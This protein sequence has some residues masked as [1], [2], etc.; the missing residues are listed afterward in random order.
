MST[1]PVPRPQEY[2]EILSNLRTY[3]EDELANRPLLTRDQYVDE[4]YVR[5][6]LD[7]WN[8]QGDARYMAQLDESRTTQLDSYISLHKRSLVLRILPYITRPLEDAMGRIPS[9]SIAIYVTFTGNTGGVT[10]PVGLTGPACDIVK[11]QY[12]RT[13]GNSALG[14]ENQD[15]FNPSALMNSLAS[16]QTALEI[17]IKIA[18]SGM[19]V[20]SFPA[21]KPVYPDQ[22]PMERDDLFFN[23]KSIITGTLLR[24]DQNVPLDR[25]QC[26]SGPSIVP[27]KFKRQSTIARDPMSSEFSS[28][29]TRSV[30]NRTTTFD[31]FFNLSSVPLVIGTKEVVPPLCTLRSWKS[32]N[33]SLNENSIE[34]FLASKLTATNPVIKNAIQTV[35]RILKLM[36][37]ILGESGVNGVD[38]FLEHTT[39]AYLI[40]LGRDVINI[41]LAIC[42]LGNLAYVNASTLKKG[43][44]ASDQEQ[45]VRFISASNLSSLQSVYENSEVPD[46]MSFDFLS[47]FG[48]DAWKIMSAMMLE[49]SKGAPKD[50]TP[51]ANIK[52][53]TKELLDTLEQSTDLSACALLSLTGV[54]DSEQVIE[55]S[56]PR[57]IRAMLDTKNII[58]QAE[59]SLRQLRVFAAKEGETRARID[60]FPG[61][62]DRPLLS[63]TIIYDPV[64]LR[65]REVLMKSAKL[66]VDFR[67]LTKHIGVPFRD[68]TTSAPST[69]LPLSD[70]LVAAY[71]LAV[72]YYSDLS[73]LGP[74]A[75]LECFQA[76]GLSSQ[77]DAK[78]LCD[79]LRNIEDIIRNI[80]DRND[81]KRYPKHV[82]E[83]YSLLKPL[84]DEADR[85]VPTIFEPLFPGIHRFSIPIDG[86]V[87]FRRKAGDTTYCDAKVLSTEENCKFFYV[88][89]ESPSEEPRLDLRSEPRMVA[90]ED[91]DPGPKR[92]RQTESLQRPRSPY[93]QDPEPKRLR[94]DE[95]Q[96]ALS[97]AW[98]GSDGKVQGV[99]ILQ[100][101]PSIILNARRLLQNDM[102]SAP[103]SLRSSWGNLESSVDLHVKKIFI[104]QG[105]YDDVWL[106]KLPPEH[107]RDFKEMMRQGDGVRCN[108]VVPYKTGV[109]DFTLNALVVTKGGCSITFDYGNHA[110]FPYWD[111]RALGARMSS[112]TVT[113]TLEGKSIILFGGSQVFKL[114]PMT[115][116][117]EV[118]FFV[119]VISTDKR[120]ESAFRPIDKEEHINVETAPTWFTRGSTRNASLSLLYAATLQYVSLLRKD[121]PSPMPL[122]SPPPEEQFVLPFA[123]S[124]DSPVAIPV[125]EPCPFCRKPATQQY[126]Y[127]VY[128]KE[129]AKKLDSA[130]PSDWEKG[131]K[132]C[133]SCK[134]SLDDMLFALEDDF[135]AEVAFVQRPVEYL[136][137]PIR[138]EPQAL[139][140]LVAA[141]R[142]Q[143]M[144]PSRPRPATTTGAQV[145]ADPSLL[146]LQHM[147][148]GWGFSLIYTESTSGFEAFAKKY[149][150]LLC[151]ENNSARIQRAYI[152]HYLKQSDIMYRI[153]WAAQPVAFLLLMSNK[154]EKKLYLPLVCK[155]PVFLNKEEGVQEAPLRFGS[156]LLYAAIK[157]A[158]LIGFPISLHASRAK[159]VGWYK[160]HGFL[161]DDPLTPLQ[162]NTPQKV[163]EAYEYFLRT[164]G[165]QDEDG[166]KEF[167]RYTYENAE[168]IGYSMSIPEDLL[169]RAVTTCTNYITTEIEQKS[170]QKLAGY[171]QSDF[172]LEERKPSSRQDL[173]RKSDQAARL[174]ATKTP[175]HEKLDFETAI[176][177]L[178]SAF[179]T[180]VHLNRRKVAGNPDVPDAEMADLTM[181]PAGTVMAKM[182]G[183][184][185]LRNNVALAVKKGRY[186]SD[187]T[188]HVWF[189]IFQYMDEA[190]LLNTF[191]AFSERPD[192]LEMTM[193]YSQYIR[194]QISM[195][196]DN[197]R[198]LE[199]FLTPDVSP[200]CLLTQYP[201]G[202]PVKEWA[203]FKAELQQSLLGS[204]KN[205]LV[206]GLNQLR[207]LEVIPNVI[208]VTVISSR[209]ET[210][211]ERFITET[212]KEM[213]R[214]K[215]LWKGWLPDMEHLTIND[216]TRFIPQTR[217]ILKKDSDPPDAYEGLGQH[218]EENG[219]VGRLFPS[220][221]IL[222]VEG[223][224]HLRYRDLAMLGLL[225]VEGIQRGD[226]IFERDGYQSRT[227]LNANEWPWWTRGPRMRINHLEELKASF[228]PHVSFRSVIESDSLL[229]LTCNGRCLGSDALSESNAEEDTFAMPP[230]VCDFPNLTSLT[231][232]VV[233]KR[234]TDR[235]I[236]KYL[237]R[238]FP[239][240]LTLAT[241]GESV[242][243]SL[244]HHRYPNLESLRV[245]NFHGE[246]KFNA[247]FSDETMSFTAPKLKTLIMPG[248]HLLEEQ[249]YPVVQ[250]L[251]NMDSPLFPNLETLELSILAFGNGTLL[252]NF[253]LLMRVRT[254][255][256]NYVRPA[257]APNALNILPRDTN[258]D[259]VFST[260]R[261]AIQEMVCN[262]GVRLIVRDLHLTGMSDRRTTYTFAGLRL[263]KQGHSAPNN[264]YSAAYI[265]IGQGTD[266][267]YSEEWENAWPLCQAN[268]QLPSVEAYIDKSW[269]ATV[270]PSF[271][272]DGN[273]ARLELENFRGDI[274]DVYR[275]FP[276]THILRIGP[277][278]K[279]QGYTDLEELLSIAFSNERTVLDKDQPPG[280]RL[281]L[282]PRMDCIGGAMYPC[283]YVVACRI[284]EH[285]PGSSGD[286]D[287]RRLNCFIA[288]LPL[289]WSMP[290]PPFLKNPSTRLPEDPFLENLATC[291]VQGVL[292][293]QPDENLPVPV[294][295]LRLGHFF[296][297]SFRLSE[298]TSQRLPD[299]FYRQN[300]RQP[301][302]NQR[303]LVREIQQFLKGGYITMSSRDMTSCEVNFDQRNRDLAQTIL[304]TRAEVV[305]CSEGFGLDIV[306]QLEEVSELTVYPKGTHPDPSF[307]KHWPNSRHSLSKIA[308]G[309]RTLRFKPYF[310]LRTSGQV[311]S[312]IN[313]NAEQTINFRLRHRFYDPESHTPKPKDRVP[314][315]LPK[316][317]HLDYQCEYLDEELALDIA[318]V[319]RGTRT[320]L[321]PQGLV[322]LVITCSDKNGGMDG[323][324]QFPDAWRGNSVKTLRVIGSVP[325]GFDGWIFPVL[326][327]LEIDHRKLNGLNP[328]EARSGPGGYSRSPTGNL[329]AWNFPDLSRLAIFHVFNN[330][331]H[332]FSARIVNEDKS[333]VFTAPLL[334]TLELRNID[335]DF[336]EPTWQAPSLKKIT[337]TSR[338]PN[339][340]RDVQRKF[341]SVNLRTPE[342]NP[343]IHGIFTTLAADGFKKVA[344]SG[345][346]EGSSPGSE[347][348]FYM[349]NSSFNTDTYMCM[350]QQSGSD[351]HLLLLFRTSLEGN[352]AESILSVSDA[353]KIAKATGIKGMQALGELIST[354]I[355]NG[356]IVSFSDHELPM[357]NVEGSDSIGEMDLAEF[358]YDKIT[359]S[360][361]TSVVLLGAKLNSFT[362]G[363]IPMILFI[364]VL[365]AIPTLTII[366]AA[367]ESI[368]ELLQKGAEGNL[369]DLASL[370]IVSSL[371][372]PE[373]SCYSRL[374]P[375]N[376]SSEDTTSPVKFK[377]LPGDYTVNRNWPVWTNIDDS[378]RIEYGRL[379]VQ[380]LD[381]VGFNFDSKCL[382][383]L[384]LADLIDTDLRGQR[385]KRTY[386]VRPTLKHLR[387]DLDEQALSNG[388]PDE[389]RSSYLVELVVRA[390]SASMDPVDSSVFWEFPNLQILELYNVIMATGVI[391]APKLK[392]FVFNSEKPALRL[393]T[394]NNPFH[395]IVS[396]TRGLWQLKP[397]NHSALEH[398]ETNYTAS[399]SSVSLTSVP[400]LEA[401]G[402]NVNQNFPVLK[403]LAVSNLWLI[404]SDR[405]FMVAHYNP[406]AL[407]PSL[408]HLHCSEATFAIPP[409]RTVLIG[410]DADDTRETFFT[411][412]GLDYTSGDPD[413][414][415]VV[416][417][418]STVTYLVVNKLHI[419]DADD[420][421]NP[422]SSRAVS[423]GRS[424]S[425]K[426]FHFGSPL[427]S[428][429][430][431]KVT[432]LEIDHW[433]P[434]AWLK[435]PPDTRPDITELYI[436][437][438]R[439]ERVSELR[440]LVVLPHWTLDNPSFE[441]LSATLYPILRTYYPCLES[442]KLSEKSEEVVCPKYDL[443]E[444]L[445]ATE[446]CRQKTSGNTH[447]WELKGCLDVIRYENVRVAVEELKDNFARYSFSHLDSVWEFCSMDI[448]MDATMDAFV[449]KYEEPE[450]PQ[451][452]EE[453]LMPYDSRH[454]EE[455]RK[456][457]SL[458]SRA[459]RGSLNEAIVP[460]VSLALPHG[461][462][463]IKL[464]RNIKTLEIRC[465]TSDE[466][467]AAFSHKE[468]NHALATVETLVF[469]LEP[470]AKTYEHG[471][472]SG[473]PR[474]VYRDWSLPKLRTL[475]F[476]RIPVQL[477]HLD[478]L[479]LIT[480]SWYLEKAI[481][482]INQITAFHAFV[483]D[484]ADIHGHDM[485]N[486]GVY[487]ASIEQF[488]VTGPGQIQNVDFPNA[489]TETR[490]KPRLELS[491]GPRLIQQ[492]PEDSGALRISCAST[493]EILGELAKLTQ[494]QLRH[495][496]HLH[497]NRKE[498][499]TG[500]EDWYIPESWPDYAMPSLIGVFFHKIPVFT[501]HLDCLGLRDQHGTG[502][503]KDDPEGPVWVKQL[504]HLKAHFVISPTELDPLQ[505]LKQRGIA[506]ATIE[507]LEYTGVELNIDATRLPNLI[508][509]CSNG[510]WGKGPEALRLKFPA[511]QIEGA[512]DEDLRRSATTR[513]KFPPGTVR[514]TR[515]G[516][517]TFFNVTSRNGTLLT[518][519]V[520][521]LPRDQTQ[522]VATIINKK[523][524]LY[525]VSKSLDLSDLAIYAPRYILR[526]PSNPLNVTI[527]EEDYF[528]D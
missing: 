237:D 511:I 143:P 377:V 138:A 288:R 65:L 49:D 58:S 83:L 499:A 88:Q 407:F 238:V 466:L 18:S 363:F 360:K 213:V 506:S 222:H 296:Q 459:K 165:K 21:K 164:T 5:S 447:Q 347:R 17:D 259:C 320:L 73:S 297:A 481:P 122:V 456:W 351:H 430:L 364:P 98:H 29:T 423:K 437:S 395:I 334:K 31:L 324:G 299:W 433:E 265:E 512:S 171:T 187:V 210:Y 89:Y 221:K 253:P 146:I 438:N 478:C 398:Y 251:P 93:D 27:A 350:Y 382:Y 38:V 366:N 408:T 342:S 218:F 119:Y 224:G 400:D 154:I 461:L 116:D 470:T 276:S 267:A 513:T 380:Q 379:P 523:L 429:N 42:G 295:K 52:G 275:A 349:F 94:D 443:D 358:L 13:Y 12:F 450:L 141:P 260:K 488:T 206:N 208:K 130:A 404:L 516:D 359:E 225:S 397:G 137:P 474:F 189:M 475:R 495:T 348:A 457:V 270:P 263:V 239:K 432:S 315:S 308:R 156:I 402:R 355:G 487:S 177:S 139:K 53:L 166:A 121:S 211:Q 37:S 147:L 454:S 341:P 497:F 150:K 365:R 23:R 323:P 528:I 33:S 522:P 7:T 242:L 40:V 333:K 374:C 194:I 455:N 257:F 414:K 111:L 300:R 362:P 117:F 510:M 426:L 424:Y 463:L 390:V 99:D 76:H 168:P 396:M 132:R 386:A 417:I 176:A 394:P 92:L 91:A 399:L 330:Q 230:S 444:L 128:W 252:Q 471:T 264:G 63:D 331:T 393:K 212:I 169:E 232:N 34:K 118:E 161:V 441:S 515:G 301:V 476:N 185:P 282:G 30:M 82:Q 44:G 61:T 236:Y 378:M 406:F 505:D 465:S 174:V 274:K 160:R 413:R 479:G 107:T 39:I 311:D 96:Y 388:F 196:I 36:D 110:L 313:F 215:E 367:F 520:Q 306:G 26:T 204:K 45:L 317:K 240:T 258:R 307:Y 195:S 526:E 508:S 291:L 191:T 125:N 167:L 392:R 271:V 123:D 278:Y 158:R 155:R 503:T 149:K 335:W 368:L 439:R 133:T 336:D 190:D 353:F 494:E 41:P 179:D 198:L 131:V 514:V 244:P 435:E 318:F 327:D 255:L 20:C 56:K 519:A 126:E 460:R 66:E 287:D 8:T 202:I 384:G 517:T 3:L 293:D 261:F 329:W 518:L 108:T 170:Y 281:V 186:V 54:F 129:L 493:E 521:Y 462:P 100:Q 172:R 32:D 389:L 74:D 415:E 152:S 105:K 112:N 106:H 243:L 283:F 268:C 84:Q 57:I 51:S 381:L 75:S 489:E 157:H 203:V 303:F 371:L 79:F 233:D 69:H 64:L 509:L 289:T 321:L 219:N 319:V 19:I 412:D 182:E 200:T 467:Q 328:D 473:S 250:Q 178:M 332:V 77:L 95:D 50:T 163:H 223:V 449:P 451:R 305:E 312:F 409:S 81:D 16:T 173:K 175:A 209:S 504:K 337:S 115:G 193:A 346:S 113:Y 440:R 228:A 434:R 231:F 266:F 229:T 325:V 272:N 15:T 469:T 492:A 87:V 22:D 101:R 205:M 285:T 322:S 220:L 294:K 254:N 104:R 78:E 14:Y 43:L 241:P 482:Q 47:F 10:L 298:Q 373:I 180:R 428:L 24:L 418:H 103:A 124:S 383:Y 372:D 527:V 448:K 207:H 245:Y 431:S 140:R 468:L 102:I 316:L 120:T 199:S 280:L 62:I 9:D 525:P 247:D 302:V 71:F 524:E 25:L 201:H 445:V 477:W 310:D 420:R 85:I 436:S 97:Y 484:G 227:V 421:I 134:S 80:T 491:E 483:I 142:R 403:T 226:V 357:F 304:K 391:D 28:E 248:S 60:V 11:E 411:C 217:E 153:D 352:W 419:Y 144:T 309:I 181:V 55:T 502:G 480:P 188:R 501:W 90:G 290:D 452:M 256:L 446:V 127:I 192:G 500:I 6:L 2:G 375:A 486:D 162:P 339:L 234:T 416:L 326:Q 214:L 376:D 369:R 145:L 464:L 216:I 59:P 114:S 35:I 422:S 286:Q 70:K 67:D 197:I 48:S 86:Y 279:L 262:F 277:A 507:K 425:L 183:V 184:L 410:Q 387:I 246:M 453:D 345:D 1:N 496:T 340:A 284:T 356:L 135:P 249:F 354:D 338:E 442:Y 385:S 370:R 273:L 458:M 361:V 498:D 401:F 151:I 148:S 109:Y 314:W 72:Y 136:P 292:P 235:Y 159:L 485:W 472:Q 68:A 269:T 427:S 344:T 405:Q 4:T 46:Q 490:K 343:W